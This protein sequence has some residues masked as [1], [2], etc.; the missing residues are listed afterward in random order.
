VKIQPQMMKRR[1]APILENGTVPPKRVPNSERR[2]RECLTP[3]EIKRLI[4]VAR[5]RGCYGPRDALMI[6]IAYSWAG[7]RLHFGS[8][9]FSRCST[10]FGGRQPPVG[11]GWDEAL[12]S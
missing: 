7:P 11:D 4:D 10:D 5:K 9:R 8:C 12:S 3:S 2:P 1:K 6:L